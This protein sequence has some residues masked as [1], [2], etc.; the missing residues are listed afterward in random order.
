M[1]QT[2]RARESAV[3]ISDTESAEQELYSSIQKWGHGA[4]PINAASRSRAGQPMWTQANAGD[5]QKKVSAN[6]GYETANFSKRQAL[7]HRQEYSN[8]SFSPTFRTRLYMN[9]GNR[10]DCLIGP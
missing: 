2:I 5:S 4:K 7:L 3:R 8:H 10:L 6:N 9:E 1:N